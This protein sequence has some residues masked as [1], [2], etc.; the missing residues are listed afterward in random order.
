MLVLRLMLLTTF[1][2]ISSTI[3][4]ILFKKYNLDILNFKNLKSE[5]IVSIETPIA[6]KP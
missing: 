6:L 1:Q 4:A 2:Y 3:D 5:T